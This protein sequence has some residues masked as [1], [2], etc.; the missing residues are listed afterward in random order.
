[1][2]RN[3]VVIGG[4]FGGLSSAGLLAKQGY[5]VTVLEKN[6]V[7]GGRARVWETD[8]FVFDMGPSWYLMPEVFERYFTQLG[9][10][11]K[12]YYDLYKL[13]PYYR[14]FFGNGAEPVDITQDHEH[15]RQVFE[16]FEPGGAVKLDAYLKQ[17][18]YKYRVAMDEFLYREYRHIFQFLNWRLMTEGLKLNVFSNLDRFV[19]RYFTDPRARHI[20]EYAMVFLGSSPQNAPALYSIMS[21][22]DLNLGVYFP[23]GGMTKLVQGMAKAAEELGTEFRTGTPATGIGYRNGAVTEVHTPSGAVPADLVVVNADYAWADRNLLPEGMRNYSDGYWDKRVMAPTMFIIYLGLSK[24]V[25]QLV[26]H[27]LYFSPDWDGHFDAI[28]GKNKRWPD[29]PSYYVSCASHDDPGVAPEGKE[30]I[31]FLVPVAAGLEDDP[32]FRE[33]YAE[34]ILDH[35][36]GMIGERIRDHIQIKRLFSHRDFAGDYNALKGTALGISHTLGQTA[37]FR[38]RMRHRKLGNM[39]FAGQYTHP[40]IGVPMTL[41]ASEIISDIV[42]RELPA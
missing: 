21:H 7:L 29:S 14:V 37:V 42:K 39:F 33:S 17:A 18:E 13:D 15:N 40:G 24:K 5:R 26:H 8:G 28:F 35:F 6:E 16:S 1:M 2:E 27:N 22:V 30:N 12:D 34:K 4:G 38:P 25:P 11:R 9:K 3:A 32:E 20:L 41:I 23:R 19:R 10:E 36:E 31:F